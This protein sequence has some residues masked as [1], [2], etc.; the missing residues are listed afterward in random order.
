MDAQKLDR[1]VNGRSRK[2]G[3]GTLITDLVKSLTSHEQ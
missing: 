3:N 1:Q 2:V